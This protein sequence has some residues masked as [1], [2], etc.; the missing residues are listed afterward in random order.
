MNQQKI[1]AFI[2]E[3]RIQQ[4]MNQKQLAE[5]INVSPTT[6]SKW[7]SGINIPDY[8]NLQMLSEFFGVSVA[9]LL[10]GEMTTVMEVGASGQQL[11]NE[12]ID[13]KEQESFACTKKITDIKMRKMVGVSALLLIIISVCSFAI[14]Y[15]NFARQ[16][17]NADDTITVTR[18]I[19]YEGKVNVPT[20]R[21]WSETIDGIT[22]SGTLYLLFD[23]YDAAGNQTTAVYN[24]TLTR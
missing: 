3:L 5:K 15:H 17:V 22:Y 18:T 9:E 6:I 16:T 24:G 11:G 1:G 8:A 14:W 4:G 7:E 12:E 21:W 2:R 10:N 19:V 13:E 23:D 20:S